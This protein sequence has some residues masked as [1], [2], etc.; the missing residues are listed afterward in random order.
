MKIVPYNREEGMTKNSE[1]DRV[2]TLSQ[3]RFLT[4]KKL[5]T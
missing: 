3:E 4:L 1:D 2:R 5:F